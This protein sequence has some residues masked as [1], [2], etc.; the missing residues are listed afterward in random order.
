M[1]TSVLDTPSPRVIY[2]DLET[3]GYRG[4]NKYSQKHR[5]IQ[6]AALEP[7]A[8]RSFSEYVNPEIRILQRSTEVHNITNAMVQSAD[9][10]HSVW[11]R[12]VKAFQLESGEVVLVAHNSHSFDRIVLLKELQRLDVQPRNLS[13]VRFGDSLLYFRHLAPPLLRTA[14]EKSTRARS[15]YNLSNLYQYFMGSAIP[16]AHDVGADVIALAKV[17]QAVG[18]EWTEF[19]WLPGMETDSHLWFFPVPSEDV[20]IIT[21]HGIGPARRNALQRALKSETSKLT[22]NTIRHALGTNTDPVQVETFLRTKVNF[23]DD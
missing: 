7:N 22:L 6:F 1:T 16:N 23:D 9:K 5:I 15:K 10:L 18:I 20:D 19:P 2:F 13:N 3:T 4:C 11:E 14:I 21:L 12:F 8:Q 17:C